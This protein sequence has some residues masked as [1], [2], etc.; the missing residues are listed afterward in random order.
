MGISYVLERR[1]NEFSICGLGERVFKADLV[2]SIRTPWRMIKLC[3][4]H[5]SITRKNAHNNGRGGGETYFTEE[6]HGRLFPRKIIIKP[7]Y[8]KQKKYYL[9][10]SYVYF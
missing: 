7:M 6:G 2:T 9:H 5:F 8:F 4:K 10:S 3:R 1:L